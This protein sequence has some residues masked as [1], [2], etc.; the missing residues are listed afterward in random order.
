[1]SDLHVTPELLEAANRGDLQLHVVRELVWNHLLQMCPV[2]LAG[3][4]TW[5]T[6][7]RSRPVPPA[8]LER[9]APERAEKER[10]AERDL[11]ELLALPQKQ[12]LSKIHGA[13]RRFRGLPLAHS[14]LN[15]AKERMPEQPQ[16]MHDLAEAAEQVLLRTPDASGYFDALARAT[17]Y[18]ADA[19]R[20]AGKEREAEER[21]ATARSLIRHQDAMA[22][23]VCAEVDRVEGNLRRDQGRLEEADDLLSRS[24]ALF[25]LAG[26]EVF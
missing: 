24:A 14:L 9:R 25:E 17:A 22:A 12:R 20:A 4:R 13:S 21:I 15:E 7:R 23:L 5:Q 19:L 11:R 3:F 6:A 8:I 16:E 1:L 18:R 26:D 10:Q 2:C